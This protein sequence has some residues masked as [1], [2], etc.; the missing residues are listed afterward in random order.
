MGEICGKQNVP[1]R[2]SN[3]TGTGKS[4]GLGRSA[5]AAIIRMADYFC[6]NLTFVQVAVMGALPASSR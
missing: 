2:D 1:A 6:Q 3:R 5:A 4:V